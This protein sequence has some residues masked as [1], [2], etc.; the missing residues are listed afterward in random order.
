MRAVIKEEMFLKVYFK[1]VQFVATASMKK[2]FKIG[3]N[4]LCA[5][6]IW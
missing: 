6:F 4:F 1:T 3:G 5:V 2:S